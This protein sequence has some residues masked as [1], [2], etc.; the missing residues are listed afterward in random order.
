MHTRQS[1]DGIVRHIHRLLFGLKNLNRNDR[2]EDLLLDDPRFG[3]RVLENGR[4][5]E[6]TLLA[7]PHAASD[8]GSVLLA[9]LQ[10]L[11][12]ALELQ[13]V[14]EGPDLGGL[15]GGVTDNAAGT[16]SFEGALEGLNEFVR[17][18]FLDEDAG[19]HLYR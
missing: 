12:D 8:K 19:G 11:H 17:N 15:A 10:E 18:G 1:K 5:H 13:L 16:G 9:D 2:T 3:R 6:K 4:L 14:G 7:L